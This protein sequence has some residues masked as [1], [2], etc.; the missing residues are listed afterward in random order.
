VDDLTKECPTFTTAF[1][2]SD[3]QVMRIL[4]SIALFWG[5]PATMK[6][7]KRPGFAC[8]ALVQWSFEHGVELRLIQPGK[9][10]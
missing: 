10:T 1:E 2:I 4:E 3:V 5:Y 8:R 7:D 9:L 6:T